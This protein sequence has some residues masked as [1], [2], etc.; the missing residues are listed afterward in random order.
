VSLTN[1]INT[2]GDRSII[3]QT[4]ASDYSVIEPY[5]ANTDTVNSTNIGSLFSGQRY[6]T[7]QLESVNIEQVLDASALGKEIILDFAQ[8]PGTRPSL[9]IRGEQTYTL[10]RSNGNGSFSPVPRDRYFF[11]HS[12]LNRSENAISTINADVADKSVFGQRYTYA[13]LYIVVMGIQTPAYS[14]IYSRP[15]FVGIFR[16]PEPS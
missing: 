4:L 1:E 11:N 14:P 13:A 5:T 3:S 12:D 9:T 2:Y 10:Y 6:H 16:L 15:T 7:M 8:A